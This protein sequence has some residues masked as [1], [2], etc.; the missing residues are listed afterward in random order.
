MLQPFFGTRPKVP[1]GTEKYQLILTYSD[2]DITLSLLLYYY[3]VIVSFI[4][5]IIFG[6]IGTM[7]LGYIG[8]LSESV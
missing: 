7:F 8:P 4:I 2:R 1:S 6:A 5:C 3:F